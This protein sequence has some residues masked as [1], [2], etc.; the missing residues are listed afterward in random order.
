[1]P[2]I[3]K[4]LRRRKTY[5]YIVC[6]NGIFISILDTPGLPNHVSR[7]DPL[8]VSISV[9]CGSGMKQFLHGDISFDAAR[10]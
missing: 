4:Y 1:M 2:E 9:A 6:H 3:G 10:P 5:S 7:N 8:A